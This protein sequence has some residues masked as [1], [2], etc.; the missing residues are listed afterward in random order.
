MNVLAI[1]KPAGPRLFEVV[2]PEEWAVATGQ[3]GERAELHQA[4]RHLRDDSQD[5]HVRVRC[6]QSRLRYMQRTCLSYAKRYGIYVSTH[7][8]PAGWL[9]IMRVPQAST[10]GKRPSSSEKGNTSKRKEHSK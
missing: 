1:K 4:I 2:T 7:C 10:R 6:S 3:R 8:D 5:L 9:W